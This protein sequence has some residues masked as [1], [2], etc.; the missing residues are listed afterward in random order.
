MSED[1]LLESTFGYFEATTQTLSCASL[2]AGSASLDIEELLGQGSS[3]N[4]YLARRRELHGQEGTSNSKHVILKVL[5][6]SAEE[7]QPDVSLLEKEMRVLLALQ[8][9]PNIVG[10][11]GLAW[12]EEGI[13]DEK[14][15][16]PCLAM[17]LEYCQGGDLHDK[18]SHMRFEESDGLLVVQAILTGLSH[19]H[20]LGYVHRD[21]KPENIL[22]SDGAVKI[23]DFGLCCHTSDEQEMKRSCGSV[24]HIAPEII[25]GRAYGSKVDCFSVGAILYF[26]VSGRH[27]FVGRDMRSSMIKTV[28]SPLNFRRSVRLEILSEGCKQ[29]MIELTIRDPLCRP[30]SAEAL[31][32]LWISRGRPLLQTS[33]FEEAMPINGGTANS[34]TPLVRDSIA[35]IRPEGHDHC[36]RMSERGSDN[37]LARRCTY[38]SQKKS[39][40][41]STVAWPTHPTL[42]RATSSVCDR[43]TLQSQE[44]HGT[45]AEDQCLLEM[46]HEPTKPDGPSIK[47]KIPFGLLTRRNANLRNER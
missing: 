37:M 15:H 45:E 32:N 12:V 39:R 17:Q 8:R 36:S 34:S 24:G 31:Q 40:D 11:D 46:P 9:H 29:F 30:T 28:R 27:A 18:V 43:R 42:S 47:K 22:W 25:L 3:A 23:S 19:I 20:A 10:L 44:N 16:L 14:I 21:I 6:N 5:T 41:N 2:Q 26:I 4:V 1:G 35:Q 13:N 38:E 7:F 33:N